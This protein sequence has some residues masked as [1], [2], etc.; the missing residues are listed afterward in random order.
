[1]PRILVGTQNGL[2]E[3]DLS[4]GKRAVSHAGREVTDVS[5]KSWELWAILDGS[6]VGHTA[7]VDRWFRAS[8][9]DGLSATCIADTRAG[10]VVGTSEA[11]LFRVAGD[12]LE[13]I[14]SFDDVEERSQWFTPWGG[15]PDTRSIT[16]DGDTVYVNVHVGGILRSDD[17]GVSW[18]PTIDIHEDVHCVLARPGNLLAACARGLATSPDRGSTWTIRSD[19]L[20]AEYCRGLAVCGDRVLLTASTGPGGGKSAIYRAAIAGGPFERCTAGLPEWFDHNIDSLCLDAVPDGS[21]A[22]FGTDDGEVF[23]STNGGETWAAIAS[24][25]PRVNCVLT[26][27]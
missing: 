25:M 18:H 15:P 26:L 16:E 27:P 7:G 19:G 22:A 1:M 24:D 9:L 10:V 4:S 11:R 2:H 8:E 14:S 13:A 3:L 6:E 21:L 17:E 20:H 5:P 23:A 12:G